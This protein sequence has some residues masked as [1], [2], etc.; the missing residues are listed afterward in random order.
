[1]RRKTPQKEKRA[2]PALGLA[3]LIFQRGVSPKACPSLY[4]WE[5]FPCPWLVFLCPWVA[6]LFRDPV[7]APQVAL[8]VPGD[9]RVSAAALGGP[10]DGQL[11]SALVLVPGARQASLPVPG[12]PS[13]DLRADP[14]D[15]CWVAFSV[16]QPDGQRADY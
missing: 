5:A 8:P 2:K 13:D 16:C 4:P 14:P 9:P 3:R 15:G 1:L 11:V 6:F 12:D 7:D 10:L